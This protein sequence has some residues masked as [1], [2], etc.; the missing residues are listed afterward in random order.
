[1]L[2]ATGLSLF[3]FQGLKENFGAARLAMFALLSWALPILA[4]IL[5]IAIGQNE[6]L[7]GITLLT[8][9]LSPIVIIP[10]SLIRMLPLD[11][12]ES[13][14]PEAQRAFGL[15]IVLL[16]GM[17]AWLHWRLRTLRK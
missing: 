13:H 14:G 15:S 7:I 4:A 12:M 17:N 10:L 9:A 6:D 16:T 8:A 11:M 2:L 3:Y 1:M 5:I